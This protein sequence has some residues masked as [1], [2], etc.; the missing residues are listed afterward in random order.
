MQSVLRTNSYDVKTVTSVNGL[1]YK[2]YIFISTYFLVQN[3]SMH[4]VQCAV[5]SH[6][7]PIVVQFIRNNICGGYNVRNYNFGLYLSLVFQWKLLLC[8]LIAALF[9]GITELYRD[10][11][12]SFLFSPH[13][14][15]YIFFSPFVF[16]LVVISLYYSLIFSLPVSYNRL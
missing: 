2:K 13:L 14:I 10:L 4:M 15:F 9:E 8:S 11:I 7:R 6:Y 5:H 12:L 3:R 1:E 16:F